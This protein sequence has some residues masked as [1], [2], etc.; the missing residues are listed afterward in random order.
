MQLL[1]CAAPRDVGAKI[2]MPIP[3]AKT[4]GFGCSGIS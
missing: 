2:F 1:A 3:V 4:H